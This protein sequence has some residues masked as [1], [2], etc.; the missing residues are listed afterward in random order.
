VMLAEADGTSGTPRKRLIR[1]P[2]LA[3]TAAV[4]R[5]GGGRGDAHRS[6]DV[7]GI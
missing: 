7:D 4:E 1:H 6:L 3:A 2:P 5:R